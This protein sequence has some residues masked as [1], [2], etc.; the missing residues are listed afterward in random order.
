M[1]C[2]RDNLFYWNE[3]QEMCGDDKAKNAA[4]DQGHQYVSKKNPGNKCKKEKEKKSDKN[5]CE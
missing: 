4:E 3:D 1:R 5:V 2:V